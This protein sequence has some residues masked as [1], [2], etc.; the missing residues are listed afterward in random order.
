MSVASKPVSILHLALNPL[1]GP[2]SVMRNLAQAQ[3]KSGLYAGV[4]LGV[5]V[6]HCWP[7]EYLA[8]LHSEQHW[9][10]AKTPKMFGT[11]S[12]LM[13]KLKRPPLEKWAEDLARHSNSEKVII[14]C[15]NAWMSGIFLPFKSSTVEL[16]FVATVHGVNADLVRKP[17]RKFIHRW[18]AQR[19]M[20]HHAKLTSVDQANLA[21]AYSLFGLPENLFRV[22]PN[23]ILELQAYNNHVLPVFSGNRVLTIASISSL[24]P[25]KGWEI[26]VQGVIRASENGIPC[27]LII[28]GA[29]QDATK[30]RQYAALYPN[31]IEFRGFVSNPQRTLMPSIDVLALLSQQEGL[32]MAIIE[33][34]S[35]GIPVIATSVGGISE[36]VEHERTGLLIDRDEQSL[37]RALKYL[38]DNAE[39]LKKFS[40]QSR[41]T[42]RKKFSIDNIVMEY[43]KVYQQ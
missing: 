27:K 1:T 31:I 6:D 26:A 17:I 16:Q 25:Q 2:W 12:F 21:K 7:E 11:A 41:I 29:G 39:V 10:L 40:V 23:G 5:V 3:R 8:E 32:P 34:M 35:L 9:Y 19:L 43:D 15:H 14:H 13:Q 36:A 24:I 33:A 4:G 42:F 38:S 30:A 18:M 28:A 20:Q 37:Y 22:I